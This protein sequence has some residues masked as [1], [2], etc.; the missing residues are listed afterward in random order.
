MLTEEVSEQS[1]HQL[2]KVLFLLTISPRLEPT[3]NIHHRTS[4]N[5][6][7]QNEKKVLHRVE[8]LEG[9]EQKWSSWESNPEP[10]PLSNAHKKQC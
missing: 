1:S 5:R 8:E 2:A 9:E 3:R 10:S 6:H 4:R 7:V